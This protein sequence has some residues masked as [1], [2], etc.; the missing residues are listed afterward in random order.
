M[1]SRV[2]K[3]VVIALLSSVFGIFTSC[4]SDKGMLPGDEVE[5]PALKPDQLTLN[6][7]VSYARQQAFTRADKGDEDGYLDPS[8]D[9]EK[10]K[11]LRVIIVHDLKWSDDSVPVSGIV[12][13]N[14]L[15]ATNDQGR[16][17]YDNLEFKVKADEYKRIYLIANEDYLPAPQE[18]STASQFLD[19][20]KE[21][22]D[23]Y[24]E[25]LADWTAYL[26]DYTSGRK[27][28]T[29]GLFNPTKQDNRLPLTEFF[30]IYAS[31]L[32]EAEDMCYANLFLTRAAA[33]AN[34]FL[35]TSN[36]YNNNAGDIPEANTAITAI[37][38]SGIAPMEYVFPHD[39]EYNPSKASLISN[40][41]NPSKIDKAYITDF[42]VPQGARADEQL[43]TYALNQLNV[44]I[45]KSATGDSTL[46][47]TIRP[48]YFPES[49]L[50][51]GKRYEV[52]VQIN[53]RH[54]LTAPLETNIL[55]IT[56]MENGVNVARDAIARNT[57]LPIIIKFNGAASITVEVLPWDREDYYVDYTANVG[58][59]EG[60]Y[61]SFPEQ[62]AGQTGDFLS[63]SEETGQLVL[64]YGKVARG[65]FLISS[66]LG[67]TWNAYLVTTGGVQE[68]IQ[69]QIP[70][71]NYNPENP[72]S[73]EPATINTTNISGNVGE[74]AEFGIVA[75]LAP[76]DTQNS[77]SLMVIVTLADGTPVIANVIG[78]WAC[79]KGDRPI[80]R[81][82]VIENPI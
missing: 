25:D 47:N 4:S 17:M 8:G 6:L 66:P 26:P 28:Y 72:E 31:R 79:S 81:L 53:N 70:N 64:N 78:D 18:Y 76:G 54:W 43:V 77:A 21:G 36:Y 73:N 52:S 16:P 65:R 3:Y 9:F 11:E 12:E 27:E 5:E 10:I 71:P 23:V 59:N 80:N 68:A 63:L 37:K 49:I 35:D 75:T 20:F 24:F 82:T 14:R 42:S 46:I 67:A 2:S 38:I 56:K 15:V 48:V 19:S 32:I 58:F 29:V 51:P 22:K 40:V 30:D 69:F 34:F 45:K 33:K 13:A 62:E 7:N 74:E 39:T 41:A 57:Y 1:I 60:D 55:Q 61:L 50:E 44:E